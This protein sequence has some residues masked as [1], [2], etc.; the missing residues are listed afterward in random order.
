MIQVKFPPF[1][2][3]QAWCHCQSFQN[4]QGGRGVNRLDLG[5]SKR[6]VWKHGGPVG[7]ARM[8]SDARAGRRLHPCWLAGR[9]CGYLR[10]GTAPLLRKFSAVLFGPEASADLW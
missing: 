3:E 9:R 4:H 5:G 1:E 10:Q 7:N 8:A 2:E 6:T